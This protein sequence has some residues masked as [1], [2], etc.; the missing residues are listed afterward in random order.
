MVYVVV[1]VFLVERRTEYVGDGFNKNLFSYKERL[2]KVL[3]SKD[4]AKRMMGIGI[5]L[6]SYL[7]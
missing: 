3:S 7:F 2:V 5:V 1:N 4:L 6:F